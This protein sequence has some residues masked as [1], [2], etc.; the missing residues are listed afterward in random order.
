VKGATFLPRLR[1][2]V[3]APIVAVNTGTLEDTDFK[4]P[5]SARHS[6]SMGV[7][8]T[9]SPSPTRPWTP[10]LRRM[11]RRVER[12][13]IW[14]YQ[15]R[16]Y[17]KRRPVVVLS[18][19]DAIEFLNAVIV[20][21]VTSTVLGFPGA[22]VLGQDAGLKHRSAANLDSVQTVA[23]ERLVRYVGQVPPARMREICRALAIAT[24]CGDWREPDLASAWA[25]SDDAP[26]V[27]PAPG[28]LIPEGVDMGHPQMKQ[29]R[30]S[31]Y[32]RLPPDGGSGGS[33]GGEMVGFLR[34]S[35]AWVVPPTWVRWAPGFGLAAAMIAAFLSGT[36]CSGGGGHACTPGVSTA[37]TCP[38]GRSGAQVCGQNGAGYGVCTCSGGGD[39]GTTGGGA[40]STGGGGTAG[41][42]GA[43]GS[44]G[45]TTG[46]GGSAGQAPISDGG[47]PDTTADSGHA[48]ATSPPPDAFVMSD[49][50]VVP[51]GGAVM[52]PP[53]GYTGRFAT[54]LIEDA[55]IGPGKVDHSA[56]DP[57]VAVPDQV[58][59][60]LATALGAANPVA[61]ALSVLGG[62][63]LNGAISASQKPDVYGTMRMD[64]FGTIGTELWLAAREERTEDSFTPAFPSPRGYK[65]IPIDA[66]V[67]LRVH[68]VDADLLDSDDEVGIA[69]VNA[70]DMRAALAAQK[71]Y[72]VQVSNQTSNQI[73][74]IGISVLQQ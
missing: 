46:L 44:G 67:R 8:V 10:F 22:V 6:P 70:A 71:K 36:S 60:D 23:K 38:S 54:V 74:F 62:P 17:D 9:A 48:D 42:A 7:L 2:P 37:C 41:S 52:P 12:G 56:W 4:L 28:G 49:G 35:A 51:D 57:G 50:A 3:T 43:G 18:R 53:G 64:G 32:G 5:V 15:F 68:L 63:L 13:E 31:G 14:L 27:L 39:A 16:P 61:A 69:V 24:G 26:A 58:F 47:P 19:Q 66:D 45:T 33:N 55:V 40:G 11:A 1:R 34:A 20:A 65:D 30:A 73:L 21:P 59:T 25:P 72:Q 29:Y